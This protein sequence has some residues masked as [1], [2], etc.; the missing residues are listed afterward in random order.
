MWRV[1]PWHLCRP[2]RTYLQMSPTTE[3]RQQ[4]SQWW[5]CDRQESSRVWLVLYRV[6]M[7]DSL[8]H[9]CCCCKWFPHTVVC[10]DLSDRSLMVSPARAV[11]YK[12]L[13]L[14]LKVVFLSFSPTFIQ[15]FL[16]RV[17]SNAFV[18]CD[19]DY[20]VLIVENFKHLQVLMFNEPH[21]WSCEV[22]QLVWSNLWPCSSNLN[23]GSGNFIE[24]GRYID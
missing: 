11:L 20:A 23:E 5:C 6:I 24:R 10:F 17:D 3:L 1:P 8:P 16:V 2:S 4:T 21:S 22:L 18:H 9:L 19:C 13:L 14:E 15:G 7:P 12:S